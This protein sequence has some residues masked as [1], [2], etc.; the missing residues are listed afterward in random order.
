MVIEQQIVLRPGMEQSRAVEVAIDAAGGG[1][2]RTYTYAVPAELADVAPGE[3]VL[4]EFGRRQ[5]LAIILAD[6]EP[7]DGIALKPL[8]ARVRTDGPLL[9][10]LSLELARWIAKHYLAPPAVVIRA[11]LPPGLLEPW[12]YDEAQSVELH[13]RDRSAIYG[14]FHLYR[15]RS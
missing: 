10:R 3:A 14:G 11:M 13:A 12:A 4:V 5:A 7:P 2:A 8:A 9:P 15:H 1:S 6:T